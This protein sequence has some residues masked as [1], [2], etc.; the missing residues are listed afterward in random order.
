VRNFQSG[1]TLSYDD[2]FGGR[3]FRHVETSKLGETSKL[4]VTSKTVWDVRYE[5]RQTET[6]A[7]HWKAFYE[8]LELQIYE[9][10]VHN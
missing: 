1:E 5:M 2:T 8:L 3:H 4:Y 6:D 9:W 10:T 7:E